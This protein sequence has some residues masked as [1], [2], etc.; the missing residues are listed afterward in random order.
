MTFTLINAF[1]MLVPSTTKS[2]RATAPR[3]TARSAGPTSWDGAWCG[4]TFPRTTPVAG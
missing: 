2:P 3:T 1:Q 4:S